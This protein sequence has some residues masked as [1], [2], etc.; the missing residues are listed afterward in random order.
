MPLGGVSTQS[1][2]TASERL[3]WNEHTHALFCVLAQT[4]THSHIFSSVALPTDFPSSC[5]NSAVFGE[6]SALVLLLQAHA[7]MLETGETLMKRL[8]SCS[9]DRCRLCLLKSS[10]H[11][12]KTFHHL[13]TEAQNV[14]T[15]SYLKSMQLWVIF[16]DSCVGEGIKKAL[17]QSVFLLSDMLYFYHSVSLVCF[18]RCHS[19]QRCT[20]SPI[21]EHKVKHLGKG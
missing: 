7:R 11:M 13:C 21:S 5:K 19:S 18:N 15:H 1:L 9:S 6:M 4:R 14:Q 12:K 16:H 3:K 8:N 2:T 10:Y 17:V 20:H